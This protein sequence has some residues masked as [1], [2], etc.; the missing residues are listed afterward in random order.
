MK[1]R[2]IIFILL[3]VIQLF[4]PLSMIIQKEIILDKGVIVKFQVEPVDPYDAFRGKYLNIGVVENKYD[5]ENNDFSENQDIYVLL[6]IDDDGFAQLDQ[7]SI[8]PFRND[9][10]IK[11]AI[12]FIGEEYIHIEFPFDRFY[13]NEKYSQ[14]GEDLF[15]KYSRGTRED[16]YITVKINNGKAV[17]ENMYIQG[18]EIN[19]FI[20]IEMDR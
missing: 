2:K 9:L 12:D 10:Y 20:E 3:F 14:A 6:E 19:Q 8:H 15:Q 18:I 11:C 1:Y 4:V 13:L 5:I 7:I 17:L 16:A